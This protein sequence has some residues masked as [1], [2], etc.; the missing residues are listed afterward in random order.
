MTDVRLAEAGHHAVLTWRPLA[1]AYRFA[2]LILILA[3]ILRI[4]GILTSA[5]VWNSFLFYTVLS[6]LLCLAWTA[7]LIIATI[8]D[9]RS[10]GVRGCSTPS[11]R[12]GG[13]VML[14]ITV[15]LLIYLVVLVPQSFRQGGDYVP[16]SLTDNLIHIISPLLIIVDWLAFAPKGQFR[17]T[18]PLL[19]ALIPYG[20]L[21]FAFAYGASGGEFYPG[22]NYPYPFMNVAELGVGAVALW[23]VGLTVSLLGVAYL[24]VAV[25]RWL[26]RQAGRDGVRTQVR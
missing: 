1:L 18:D 3:G 9:L 21:A 7:G 13:A 17:W 2:A 20:Y 8:K 14:A 5:P 22:V 4:S 23:I 16:F 26:G 19:W 11:A 12:L 10:A 25:D 15:T 24:Y 6:N